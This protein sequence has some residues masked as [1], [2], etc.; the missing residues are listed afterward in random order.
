MTGCDL[1]LTAEISRQLRLALQSFC[2]DAG[3]LGSAVLDQCGTQIAYGHPAALVASPAATIGNTPEIAALAAGAFAATR[4]LASRLGDHAF[5][6]LVHHGHERHFYLCPVSN[7][8]LLL[9]VFATG[10]PAG[11]VRHCASQTAPKIGA[12]LDAASTPPPGWNSRLLN[13]SPPTSAQ[14]VNTAV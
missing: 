10:T 14:V 4:E 2:T 8:Y 13:A 1:H 11:V 3:A 5:N 9:T 6:G 7:D 12:L